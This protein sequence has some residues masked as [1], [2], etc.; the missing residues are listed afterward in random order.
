MS[1][2][3]EMSS[4]SLNTGFASVEWE[5]FQQFPMSAIQTM[6]WDQLYLGQAMPMDHSTG[7]ASHPSHLCEGTEDT[8]A[9]AQ[10]H[11]LC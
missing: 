5:H 2:F 8:S 9:S 1:R 10:H 7:P 11:L 4:P 6:R 3:P